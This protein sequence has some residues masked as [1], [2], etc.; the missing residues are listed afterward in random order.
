MTADKLLSLLGL[1]RRANK[2]S[3]GHDACIQAITRRTA[4]L[5]IICSDAS[6]RLKKEFERETDFDKR[7]ITLITLPYTQQDIKKA[8]G[9][10][11]RV[12][13]VNDEG[14]AQAILRLAENQTGGNNAIC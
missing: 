7:N 10:P 2:L 6:E 9:K 3:L 4:K 5:C 12:L 11:A 14:F 13:T 1:C 8:A